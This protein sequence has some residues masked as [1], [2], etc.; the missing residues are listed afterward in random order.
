MAS[1]KLC[2]DINN[3]GWVSS[4]ADGLYN[5]EIKTTTTTTVTTTDICIAHSFG[6]STV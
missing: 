4:S 3:P 1:L 6:P 5:D 2:A